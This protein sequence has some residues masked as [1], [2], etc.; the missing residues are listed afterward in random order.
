MIFRPTNV[1]QRGYQLG[2]T[3]V[4]VWGD[5]PVFKLDRWNF[6]QML[7]LHVH[8]TT[9]NLG[10][11]KQLLFSSFHKGGPKEKK[12][13]NQKPVNPLKNLSLDFLIGIPF[14]SW[15]QLKQI[16]NDLFLVDFSHLEPLWCTLP[17]VARG[18]SREIATA[19]RQKG[20]TEVQ[21]R[22]PTL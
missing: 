21:R 6:Q 2:N 15:N 1:W 12:K 14:W 17:N 9:Q 19:A 22:P 16:E 3:K 4:C 18:K 10:S 8:E 13:K 11:S 20:L 7:D 5:S